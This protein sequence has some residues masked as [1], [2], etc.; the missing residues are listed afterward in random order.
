[1]SSEI[2][3]IDLWTG[4][5]RTD[6]YMYRPKAPPRRQTTRPKPRRVAPDWPPTNVTEPRSGTRRSASDAKAAGDSAMAASAAK[7]AETHLASRAM[8]SSDGGP[9]PG[10]GPGKGGHAYWFW[11]PL[12]TARRASRGRI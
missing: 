9:A 5:F 2:S 11:G 3:S 10:G 12:S 1:M 4:R 6:M 7:D 8:G